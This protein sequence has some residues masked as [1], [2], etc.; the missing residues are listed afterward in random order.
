M[1]RLPASL[2]A[3]ALA[4][5]TAGASAA[6]IQ[7]VNAD[8]PGQG[9]NDPTP[10]A[11]VGGN[12]GTTLGAQRLALFQHAAQIWG[13]KIESAVP[14]R[15]RVSFPEEGFGCAAA[16]GDFVYLGFAGPMS[17]WYNF[18]NAPRPNVLYPVAL[19]NALAGNVIQPET[20]E[21]QARFNP[22]MDTTPGCLTNY[23][24]F[25]YGLD[26]A[27][28][29]ADDR[30]PL[31]PLVLHELAHGLAF[32]TQTN[33]VTG[34]QFLDSPTVYDLFLFDLQQARFWDEMSDAQRAASATN[35]PNLVW[36]GA[37]VQRALSAYVRPPLRLRSG[38]TSLA[39]VV[40]PATYG[41]LVPRDGIAGQVVAAVP[42]EGCAPL[43]NAAQV[44]GKIV[45]IDR[46]T[47]LFHVKSRHAEQAGAMAVMIGNTFPEGGTPVPVLSGNDYTLTL[48]SVALAYALAEQ[49]KT[50]IQTAPA[51][52]FTLDFVPGQPDA[53]SRNGLA[54]M[55]APATLS[56]ASSVTH[57]STVA[58]GRMLMLPSI[59]TSLFDRVDLTPDLMRDIGWTLA[60]GVG[61]T[62]FL[63]EFE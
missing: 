56:T 2:F 38:T 4:F 31:L 24:G 29:P 15:V 42:A 13:S 62:V 60:P 41:P 22:F 3:F 18:P 46:G 8:P 28:A 61:H 54:Q 57:F 5:A 32:F 16:P 14:I 17:I 34:E 49:V 51:T 21:I 33:L 9:L 36:T 10:V 27:I 52:V 23:N 12:P 48:P 43:T 58:R 37:H 11:S 63:D 55:H 44:A 7:I 30:F 35:D 53:G 19:R 26:P 1:N 59:N 45:L 40:Q 39:G 25:W 47:C 20:P 50:Q 6:T